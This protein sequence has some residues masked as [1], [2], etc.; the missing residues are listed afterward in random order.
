MFNLKV[1]VIRAAVTLTCH[2]QAE[3]EPHSPAMSYI[4]MAIKSHSPTH[5]NET[6]FQG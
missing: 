2:Q 3:D 5:V 4:T 6:S 1:L